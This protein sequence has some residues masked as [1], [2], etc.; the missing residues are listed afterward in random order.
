MGGTKRMLRR[1]RIN[2]QPKL[3]SSAGD[4]PK[5]PKEAAL[6]S[7]EGSGSA[8]K[9]RSHL[10]NQD[11]VSKAPGGSREP[12]DTAEETAAGWMVF[13]GAHHV[14]RALLHSKQ[15]EISPKI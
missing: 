9:T 7:R 1:L 12:L 14:R 4:H 2:H 6:G 13:E 11:Q 3:T 15:T 8:T 10:R 5:Q